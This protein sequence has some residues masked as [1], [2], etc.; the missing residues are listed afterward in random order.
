MV[1]MKNY[2]LDFICSIA[3]VVVGLMIA[4]NLVLP[5]SWAGV[6]NTMYS[7]FG[8]ILLISFMRWL[9]KIRDEFGD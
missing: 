3:F 1:K 5:A 7:A 4:T 8:I 9:G 6:R 2:H